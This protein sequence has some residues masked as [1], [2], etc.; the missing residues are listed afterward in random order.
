MM[1]EYY[2]KHPLQSALEQ[3]AFVGKELKVFQSEWTLT[4][5]AR[6][7]IAGRIGAFEKR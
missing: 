6:Q 1:K 5:Q 7:D 4:Q 2:I 3:A